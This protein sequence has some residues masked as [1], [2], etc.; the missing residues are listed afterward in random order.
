M[1]VK[2]ILFN[3]LIFILIVLAPWPIYSAVIIAGLFLFN[4]F[5]EAFAWVIVLQLL[6][7]TNTLES[8]EFYYFVWMV[9]FLLVALGVKRIIRFYD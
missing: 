6:Y 1:L 7:G 4:R 9:V 5:G 8:S 3:L 2:R